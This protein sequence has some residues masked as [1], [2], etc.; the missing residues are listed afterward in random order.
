MAVLTRSFL[1]SSVKTGTEI[2]IISPLF[3]GFKPRLVLITAL[4][5]SSNMGFSH[6]WIV[7]VLESK[8]LTFPIWAKGVGEP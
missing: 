4:V 6:G 3:W 2:I 1:L 7:S 5:I 8:V